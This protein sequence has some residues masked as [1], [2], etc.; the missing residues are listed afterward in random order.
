MLIVYVK[1]VVGLS[2][3]SILFPRFKIF[4]FF[5]AK[6]ARV[7]K[8]NPEIRKYFVG[9]TLDIECK[10]EG[11]PLPYL[12]WTKY[13]QSVNFNDPRISIKNTK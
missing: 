10:F 6:Y 13:N 2:C 4:L 7:E 5:K 8:S 11:N 9:E 12:K 3:L 1:H